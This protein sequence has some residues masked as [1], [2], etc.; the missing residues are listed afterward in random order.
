M[1]QGTQQPSPHPPQAPEMQLLALAGHQVPLF[2]LGKTGNE[3][4]G[5]TR[6]HKRNCPQRAGEETALEAFVI[7]GQGGD[8]RTPFLEVPWGLW[9]GREGVGRVGKAEVF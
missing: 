7:P 5:E 2:H 1:I 3:S 9:A 4:G 8:I 6:T